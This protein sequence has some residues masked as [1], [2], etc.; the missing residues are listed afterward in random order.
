MD[1]VLAEMNSWKVLESS[2]M[3]SCVMLFSNI[4][5]GVTDILI[6]Y[7]FPVRCLRDISALL[8]R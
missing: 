5:I 4:G 6:G 7:L 1:G 2:Q 8:R 3:S